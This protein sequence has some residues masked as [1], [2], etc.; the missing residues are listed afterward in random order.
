MLVN[1]EMWV[2]RPNAFND[3]FDCALEP[4]R[5]K[6]TSDLQA[7]MC[8]LIDDLY[9]QKEARQKKAE[10]IDNNELRPIEEV[11]GKNVEKHILEASKMGVF[12]L[13]ETWSNILMWSHYA[14]NHTGFCVEFDRINRADNFLSHHMCRPVK[15]ESDYPNLHR[16]VDL[17]EVNLYTKAEDWSYEKEWRLVAKEGNRLL[18]L[19]APIRSITFGMKAAPE[20]IRTVQNA[21]RDLDI[22]FFQAFRSPG[23]FSLSVQAI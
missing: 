8:A 13:S 23:K 21:V 19:P 1:R 15:Y 22:D 7:Q 17:L 12:S 5:P 20:A 11:S 9:D 10:I 3:P 2:S 18:P 6:T 4:G 14:R 16:I